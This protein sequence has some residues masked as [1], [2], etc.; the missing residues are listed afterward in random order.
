MNHMTLSNDDQVS[1][2]SNDASE[3]MQS[4]LPPLKGFI[5]N[6]QQTPNQQPNI[7]MQ[8]QLSTDQ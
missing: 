1:K 3:C 5:S 6:G 4:N 2:A 7:I 8:P